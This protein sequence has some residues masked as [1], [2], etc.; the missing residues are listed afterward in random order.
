MGH[1]R[2]VWERMSKGDMGPLV[3]DFP[4]TT[5]GTGT[6]DGTT[7]DGRVLTERQRQ[8]L[9]KFFH[10]QYGRYPLTEYEFQQ[11]LQDNW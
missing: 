1:I 4:E 6:G 9:R 5:K 2:D 8:A 7:P 10:D 11:W 3:G